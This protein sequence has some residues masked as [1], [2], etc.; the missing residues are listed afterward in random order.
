MFPER[1]SGQP[2]PTLIS[3][4]CLNLHRERVAILSHILYLQS[5]FTPGDIKNICNDHIFM[6]LHF[7]SSCRSINP[8]RVLK[9]KFHFSEVLL[10]RPL[11]RF[12]NHFG[13]NVTSP[14]INC[15]RKG[16]RRTVCPSHSS[17]PIFAV[18]GRWL[19]AGVSYS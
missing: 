16:S 7:Q 3:Q 11:K 5:F 12:L 18:P 17:G 6:P 19:M 9:I 13:F 1:V 10:S 8:R 2:P 15:L 4:F 14:W